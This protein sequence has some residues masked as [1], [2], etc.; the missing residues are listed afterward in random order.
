M[1]SECPAELKDFVNVP[2]ELINMKKV[3]KTFQY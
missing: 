2:I 1:H 3:V